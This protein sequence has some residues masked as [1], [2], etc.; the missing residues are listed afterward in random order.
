VNYSG[1]RKIQN[2]AARPTQAMAAEK[3]TGYNKK[4]NEG[5]TASKETSKYS[6][7][8]KIQN[9]GARLAAVKY[10]GNL[11]KMESKRRNGQGKERCGEGFWTPI[12]PE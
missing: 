1:L 12:N 2:E 9:V 3:H 7:S 4:R 6:G 8:H 11:K 5:T 10:A